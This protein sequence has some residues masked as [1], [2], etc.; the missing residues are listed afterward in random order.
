MAPWGSRSKSGGTGDR[1][2]GGGP[3]RWGGKACLGPVT[4]IAPTKPGAPEGQTLAETA[5]EA[6]GRATVFRIKRG[7]RL[8]CWGPDEG[9]KVGLDAMRAAWVRGL[10]TD[11]WGLP[12]GATA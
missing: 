11:T 8:T 7:T 10:A 5:T 1:Q 4:P 9:D 3:E 2:G 6:D 12:T